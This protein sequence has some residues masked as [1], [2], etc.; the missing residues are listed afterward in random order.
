MEDIMS[1]NL[2]SS[3]GSP[4]AANKLLDMYYLDMRSAI[5]ETAAAL[6]RIERA[7]GGTE[8]LSDKRIQRIIKGCEILKNSSKKRSEDFLN[9]LSIE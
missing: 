9:L 8:A 4:L 5:L 6:D 3:T 2:K 1:N 7:P